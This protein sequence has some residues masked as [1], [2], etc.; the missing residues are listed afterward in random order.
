LPGGSAGRARAVVVHHRWTIIAL[1][2]VFTALAGLFGADVQSHL[3]S[4]GFED[5]R[6]ESCAEALLEET[7]GSG[8]PDVLAWRLTGTWTT[9]RWLRRGARRPRAVTPESPAASRIP[10]PSPPERRPLLEETFGSGGSGR[11]PGR[12]RG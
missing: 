12:D 3:K 11:G 8:A 7:F 5:P 10:G 4:G 9:P 1:A 2:V 6:S